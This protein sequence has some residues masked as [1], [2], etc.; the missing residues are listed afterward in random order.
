MILFLDNYDSFTYNLVDYFFRL[1][2]PCEVVRNSVDPKS[3]NWKAY[4]AIVISPGPGKPSTSGF[5]MDYLNLAIPALP[6]LGIC[7]GHQAIGEFFGANLEKG[8]FPMHGK[9]SDIKHNSD[10]LFQQIPIQFSVCRYH[11]LLLK[12]LKSPLI[13]IAETDEGEIMALK[14]IDLPVYGI[15]YHPE[16]I[17][18]EYGLQL[19]DNWCRLAL[20]K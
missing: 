6:V 3:L 8:K 2:I 5:L 12:N 20:L 17:L 16:A 9:L 19:L 15:Q 11:S 7:L 14:H 4:N 18:T 1:G 13:S 10:L